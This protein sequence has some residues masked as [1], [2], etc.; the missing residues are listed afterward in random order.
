MKRINNLYDKIIDI[1]NIKL[2]HK[3]AKKGKKPTRQTKM[4]DSDINYYCNEIKKNLQDKTFK[5]SEYV[6]F[7]KKCGKKIREIYKLPY[8]P[9]RIIHH[10]VLQQLEPIWKQI[11][12]IDTYSS[13]KG[14]GVH[15]G[16]KR[17]KKSLVNRDKTEFCFK[18]DIKKYFPSINNEILKTI[19]RKK[20]KDNDL[21]WLL[22]EIIDSTDGLPIG[23]YLS[24]YLSN[25]Y[26]NY[27]DH[28]CK[29]KLRIK[30][31]HRY[32]DDVV[33]FSSNKEEL[34]DWFHQ[35][36]NYLENN[37]KLSI[38]NNYA[39]FPVEKR[40]VDFLGYVFYHDY[41]LVRKSIK[42][43][44]KRKLKK[45]SDK[46]LE[47]STASYYG[48]LKHANCKNLHNKYLYKNNKR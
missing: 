4:V 26:L 15:F 36:K 3:N 14:R 22:D 10:A 37:L 20:I 12:I 2:A 34:W 27:F 23:N 42:E 9:D 21:L 48:W 5:N 11:L 24:Q 28:Y 39:V 45:L 31:Y 18:F 7:S 38:K 17:I 19:I 40:G 16:F 32:C 25:I 41:V 47:R 33:I 46:D 44:M 1:D 8:Y 6:V 13:I 30:Y 35:M 29:E 43:E